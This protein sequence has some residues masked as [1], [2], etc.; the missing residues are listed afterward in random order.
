M[1]YRMALITKAD[2]MKILFVVPPYVRNIAADKLVTAH[3]VP[4]GG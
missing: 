4:D 1:D 2:T 3:M